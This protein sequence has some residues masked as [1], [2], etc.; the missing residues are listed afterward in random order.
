MMPDED[1]EDELLTEVRN[2]LKT[3]I[4]AMPL[5]ELRAKEAQF[6]RILSDRRVRDKDE[7]EAART[8]LAEWLRQ[9]QRREMH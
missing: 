3:K 8:R 1:E 5:A 7:I 9:E 4:M 6:R 2:R